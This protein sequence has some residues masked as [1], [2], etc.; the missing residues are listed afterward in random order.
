ME[1]AARLQTFC[2][3]GSQQNLYRKFIKGKCFFYIYIYFHIYFILIF[4]YIF[5]TNVL[6]AIVIYNYSKL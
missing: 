4:I 3:A 6:L 5:N 2:N 1:A